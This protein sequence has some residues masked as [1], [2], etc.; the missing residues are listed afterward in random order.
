MVWKK[1]GMYE[2]YCYVRFTLS[3][4]AVRECIAVELDG[5]V[6]LRI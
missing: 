2:S 6:F 1:S 3:G 5:F 4:M